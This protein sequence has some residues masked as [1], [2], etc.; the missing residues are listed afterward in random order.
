MTFHF[1]RKMKYWIK[2]TSSLPD[3]LVF[4]LYSPHSSVWMLSSRNTALFA[5]FLHKIHWLQVPLHSYSVF[6]CEKSTFSSMPEYNW[7]TDFFFPSPHNIQIALLSSFWFSSWRLTPCILYALF[8]LYND[9]SNFFRIFTHKRSF[10][11]IF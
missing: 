3:S 5:I 2:F 9:C 4:H 7:F 6:T 10:Y 1:K 11:E 8:L